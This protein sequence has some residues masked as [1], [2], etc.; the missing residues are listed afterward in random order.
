MSASVDRRSLRVEI[1]DGVAEV[2]LLGPGKGNAMGPDFWREMPSAFEALDR[3]PAV[4]AV[5]VRGDGGNFSYGLD[6]MAMAGEMGPL[7][8]GPQMASERQKLL[9]LVGDLQ[10][11]FNRVAECRKPV[12]AAVAGW[13]IG[14]GL[15]L[16]AA[17]DIRLS[18]KEARFSLREVKVAMVADLGSLQRLPAIIGQ[19]ATRELAFTGKN[20]DADRALRIGLVS[21]V[22]ATEAE[23]LTA[24][25][26]MAKEITENSSVVVQGV[27]QV[28]NDCSGL[29]V[30]EGLRH[31]ALWNSAF[32]QSMDLAEAF[33]AFAERRPPR[34][35]GK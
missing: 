4:R 34:F 26:A 6:L 23:L 32:L 18:T 16:I 15:D 20:I 12:I 3:D 8:S 2:V 10:R 24:A 14:G 5:I 31:V 28:M 11:A 9:D 22:F 13:C 29:S 1:A 17:C 19:G 7:I 25:R 27:K 35:Q 33:A 30:S 21:D